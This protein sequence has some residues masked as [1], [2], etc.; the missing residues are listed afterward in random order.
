MYLMAALAGGKKCK[1]HT[2]CLAVLHS[3]RGARLEYLRTDSRR[4]L[5]GAEISISGC[6][7]IKVHNIFLFS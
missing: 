1:K 6:N 4:Q 7:D 3:E 5:M 2:F